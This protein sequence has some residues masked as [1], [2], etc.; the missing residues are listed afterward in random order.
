MHSCLECRRRK[1][2][3]NKTSPC[4]SCSKL[5]RDCVYSDDGQTHAPS[6]PDPKQSRDQTFSESDCISETLTRMT[7]RISSGALRR[8]QI[9]EILGETPKATPTQA[10]RGNFERG[11]GDS[12]REDQRSF[13]TLESSSLFTSH[14]PAVFKQRLSEPKGKDWSKLSTVVFAPDSPNADKTYPRSKDKE[15]PHEECHGLPGLSQRIQ[16][17]LF[18]ERQACQVLNRKHES[19]PATHWDVLLREMEWMRMDFRRER[20]WKTSVVKMLADTCACWV[21]SS[22]EERESLSVKIHRAQVIYMLR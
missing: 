11:F 21:A 4:Q 7:T 5:S 15:T 22:K 16:T 1:K 6:S 3:C 17:A 14:D 18:K 13:Q 19:R 20:K 9:S 10:D 8:K 12:H 2:Q